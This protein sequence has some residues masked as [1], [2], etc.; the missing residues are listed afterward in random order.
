[1][2]E[3][4]ITNII[5][6]VTLL[7]SIRAL[8]NPELFYKMKF[9]PSVMDR[10]DQAY[11]FLSYALVHADYMHL[12]IN[13]YVLYTFGN[14][15]EDMYGLAFDAKGKLYFVL[16]YWAAAFTSVIPSFEKHKTH[17][18]YTA[19]GAS[20]A[21]SAVVFASIM[22]NPT[23]GMG[24]LFIPFYIP[25]WLFGLL[26]LGYSYFMAQKGKDNIGHDAH[27]FGALFGIMFTVLLNYKIGVAFV[28]TIFGN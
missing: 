7:F 22:F 6:G 13:M 15:T 24:L 10:K 21:V 14:F 4:S 19:V 25:S 1:M 26:Y 5:I 11:R 27:F 3:L 20:G 8:S 18:W 23:A 12:G 9:Y 28:N 16:L 2:P 17:T